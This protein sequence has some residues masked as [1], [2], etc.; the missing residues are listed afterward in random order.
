MEE[1][2]YLD[3][4]YSIPGISFCMKSGRFTIFKTTLDVMGYP[5]Y[6]RFLYNAKERKL[7]IEPCMIDSQGAY[8]LVNVKKEE[9]YDVSS[10]DFVRMMYRENRWNRRIS[11]RIAG[12]AFP[13]ERAVEF[14]LTAALEIHEGRV[15]RTTASFQEGSQFKAAE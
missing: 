12:W 2:Q 3:W 5:E 15:M 11:Y 1:Q 6:Y 13:E 10:V 4:D 14:D 9:S 7:A 8:A